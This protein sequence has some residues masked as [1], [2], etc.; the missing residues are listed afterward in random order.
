VKQQSLLIEDDG[1]EQSFE[2]VHSL[3]N[4]LVCDLQNGPKGRAI[5]YRHGSVIR[6]VNLSDQVAK[7][8]FVVDV[9]NDLDAQQTKPAKAPGI[10]RQT[11]HNYLESHE[12][13]GD[14]G[15]VYSHIVTV[16]SR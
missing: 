3:G 8:R 6:I 7:K 9:V 5:P 1:C 16:F 12:Y 4:D 13:F 10:S 15:L 11:I 2:H 14:E